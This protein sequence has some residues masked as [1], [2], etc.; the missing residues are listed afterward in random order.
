ML[1]MM[2]MLCQQLH[3]ATVPLGISSCKLPLTEL[4]SS[5]PSLLKSAFTHLCPCHCPA[6]LVDAVH[7][8]E[9]GVLQ[10]PPGRWALYRVEPKALFNKLQTCFTQVWASGSH[11]SKV[12]V[13]PLRKL[14]LEVPELGDPGPHLLSGCSEHTKHL[15]DGVYLR[16]ARKKGLGGGHLCGDASK[17]PY[18]DWVSILA[19]TEK[20]LRRAVP[21]GHYL[22]RVGFQRY[23]K[24]T[25]ETKIGQLEAEPCNVDED[26]LRLEVP[27]QNAVAMAILNTTEALARGALQHVGIH[28]GTKSLQI[29]AKI[30]VEEIKD[31]I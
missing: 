10:E 28:K 18:V 6:L 2:S 31:E 22:V 3:D 12:C 11:I 20:N 26:V 7:T 29:N 25:C 16:V 21:E 14:L 9:K 17:G 1:E 5:T 23:R 4:L 30:H 8:I 15:E 19:L 13:L 24:R 27:M